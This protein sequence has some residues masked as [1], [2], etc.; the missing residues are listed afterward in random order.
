MKYLYTIPL[1]Y[2]QHVHLFFL[3][4]AVWLSLT[5]FLG[6]V[7]SNVI[8]L[9]LHGV[10]IT[11]KIAV[12]LKTPQLLSL[13]L[14]CLIVANYMPVHFS[15][16]ELKLAVFCSWGF[17]LLSRLW[18]MRSDQPYCGTSEVSYSMQRSTMYFCQ[19]I[20]GFVSFFHK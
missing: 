12:D 7:N 5:L 1:W 9:L 6:W 8:H 4:D 13:L 10:A 20:V 2:F 18:Q 17:R 3:Q 16:K 19:G 11:C 14:I 15:A